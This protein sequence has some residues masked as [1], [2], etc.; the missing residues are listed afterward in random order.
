MEEK[1]LA[2]HMKVRELTQEDPTY[3]ESS[4]HVIMIAN[5]LT[6]LI[7]F[8]MLQQNTHIFERFPLIE[9]E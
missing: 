2:K 1:N 6:L 4:E 9:D 5:G 8:S 3:G 7:R